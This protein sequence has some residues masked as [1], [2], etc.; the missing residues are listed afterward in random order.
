[1]SEL[2][3]LDS[4]YQAGKYR[5]VEADLEAFIRKH[6]HQI[7]RFRDELLGKLKGV[8]PTDDL[9]IRWYLLQIRSI[10]PVDEIR[11]EL[12]EIERE[13][14]YQGERSQGRVDRASVARQ[15]CYRHAPGWR[16]HRVLAIVYCYE[17]NKERYIKILDEP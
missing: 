5:T 12:E 14:W 1:M 7:R 15:W 4:E 6:R 10:N 16:D 9:A 11:E 3:K 17:R 2:E 13:I 8:T